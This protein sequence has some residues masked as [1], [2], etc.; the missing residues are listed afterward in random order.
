MKL[1]SVCIDVIEK[2]QLYCGTVSVCVT[3]SGLLTVSDD[4]NIEFISDSFSHLFLGYTCNDLVGKVRF[5]YLSFV[6]NSIQ[7][8][9]ITFFSSCKR[10][11]HHQ[12]SSSSYLSTKH[13]DKPQHITSL[14]TSQEIQFS[15]ELVQSC[16]CSN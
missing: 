14:T 12:F 4:G 13:V 5:A 6:N 11:Y 8:E 9:F 10:A 3:M 16:S 1:T 7:P 15:K 2:T